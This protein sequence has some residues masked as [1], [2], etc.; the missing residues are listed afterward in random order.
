MEWKENE[1]L[2]EEVY[3]RVRFDLDIARRLSRLED[4]NIPPYKPMP[5]LPKTDYGAYILP[6]EYVIELRKFNIPKP[7]IEKRGWW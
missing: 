1:L 5:S 6:L 3:Q 4:K 7:T 2:N